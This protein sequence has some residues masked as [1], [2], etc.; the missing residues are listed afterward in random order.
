MI[1]SLFISHSWPMLA[2]E[3]N[4]YTGFLE[5]LAAH[6]PAPKAVVLFSA[7][8]ESEV[9]TVGSTDDTFETIYDFG[10]FAPELYTLKYP[11]K[12]STAIAAA[13]QCAFERNGIAAQSD[14]QRGRINAFEESDFVSISLD[15]RFTGKWSNQRRKYFPTF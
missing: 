7:H 14:S 1:P 2:L 13:V 11:A 6:Y 4:R 5:G 12:G 3:Q 8:W 10:G 15:E 9:V